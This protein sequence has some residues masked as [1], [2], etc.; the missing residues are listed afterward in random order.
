MEKMIGIIGCNFSTGKFSL[1]TKNRPI[2]TIPFAGRYRLID[3]PISNMTNSHITS[4]GVI[5]PHLY[6][7]IIDHI[8]SG[9]EWG[10]SRKSGGLFI[11][12]G[13]S[14]G[15]DAGKGKLSIKD[16]KGNMTFFKKAS[17]KYVIIAVPGKIFNID[18]EE[19]LEHHK[20]SGAGIT[21]IY[22]HMDESSS[23]EKEVSI[24]NNNVVGIKKAKT[25]GGDIFL[26]TLIIDNDILE[27]FIDWYKDNSYLDLID[28]INE[29]ISHIKV[30]AYEFT[31]YVASINNVKEYMKESF[32]MLDA[33]VIKEIFLK[34]DRIIKTKIHD[35]PPAK[36]G[37]KSKVTNSIVGTGSKI[38]GEVKDSVIFR[39]CII[40]EKTKI[41]N[42]VIMQGSVISEGANLENVIIEKDV[43]IL[44]GAV[45]KGSQDKP[46]IITKEQNG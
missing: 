11:L 7:S 8:G 6:R 39:D 20:K 1:L 38:D 23:D 42:S 21:L 28:V 19:V 44:A 10:L 25:S 36:Y 31:G 14:Y 41:S 3:F 37:E 12:P 29:N 18:Y 45:L 24:K 43:I 40:E 32:D 17:G 46:L 33:D 22:K 16:L 5:T 13:T 26:D 35:A 9:K 30:S 4:V 2:A 34:D 27:K 15:F